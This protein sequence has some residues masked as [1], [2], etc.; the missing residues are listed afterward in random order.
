[1]KD[2]GFATT[3]VGQVWANP[4]PEVFCSRCR[5]R[6]T[7]GEVK[8][9]KHTVCGEK[10]ENKVG[11]SFN[12]LIRVF[13]DQYGLPIDNYLV[14]PRDGLVQL[15]DELSGLDINLNAKATLNGKSFSAGV[16][17]LTGAQAVEYATT[18]NYKD[19]PKTDLE[20]MARQREFFS[21]LL[22]RL[23]ACD[24][25]D[26]YYVD[27]N[28]GSTKGM[29]GRLMN[30]ADPVRFNT[31]SFGKARLL[32]VSD[33]A[34][35]KMK[36]SEAMARFIYAVSRVPLDKISFSVLPGESIKSGTATVYSIHKTKVIELLNAQMNPYGLT[37]DESTVTAPQLA[38][39]ATESDTTTVT[40]E[41]AAPV[42]SGTITTT[43]VA[44]T[45][46]TVATE[47]DTTT[48]TEA[49]KETE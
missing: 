6:V 49:T 20:R 21:A 9:N 41:S 30:G 14:I 10:L 32:N 13:N 39:K 16:Q 43:T 34:A 2:T 40:L 28:T 33:A 37:L 19:S 47:T 31:T 24:M 44:T 7:A 5:V 35:N 15:V 27:K 36:L 11:S 48:T 3:T 46:T 17:T 38:Q 42:Q 18:Y 23:A 1:G 4:Q 29:I 12:D 26:L 45:T 8:D 22:Q 25:E